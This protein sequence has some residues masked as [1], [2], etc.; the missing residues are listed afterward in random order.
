MTI[1]CNG[2]KSYSS[3]MLPLHCLIK[4]GEREGNAIISRLFN[5]IT[6]FN[7]L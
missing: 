5:T 7:E 3:D 6:L 4:E 2:N 1:I